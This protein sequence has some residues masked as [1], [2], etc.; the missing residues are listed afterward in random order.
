MSAL[1]LHFGGMDD[2]PN[3]I[4]EFRTLADLSQQELANR[5]GCSKMLVSSAER[6][7]HNIKL[8]YLQKIADV[9]AVAVADLLSDEDNPYRLSPDERQLIDAYRH[10]DDANRAILMRIAS[11][12][13]VDA[14][15]G[16]VVAA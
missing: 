13:P 1:I 14:N 2:A 4:R 12:I 7:K 8:Y 9:L 11:A 16:T 5:A 6:G 10:M 15:A 3:R